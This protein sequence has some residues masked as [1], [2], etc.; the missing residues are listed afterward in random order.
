MYA[1]IIIFRIM[2]HCSIG[3]IYVCV[4]VYY[5][6]LS[7]ESIIFYKLGNIDIFVVCSQLV[8]HHSNFV[9]DMYISRQKH[10]A[11]P[12]KD[13]VR[14]KNIHVNCKVLCTCS[15]TY[16]I[17]II[18]C[19]VDRNSTLINSSSYVKLVVMDVR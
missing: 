13:V 2:L 8:T 18:L 11:T 14:D 9:Q 12:E 3:T 10:F 16:R 6:S 5:L 17:Y 19:V 7:L 15:N 4:C 1:N